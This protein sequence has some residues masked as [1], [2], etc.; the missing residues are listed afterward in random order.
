MDDD[1]LDNDATTQATQA[2]LELEYQPP[3]RELLAVGDPAHSQWGHDPEERF[4]GGVVLSVVHTP[5]EE[6]FYTV[7]YS[8]GD[9]EFFK[10][11]RRRRPGVR[12]SLG[13]G[14]GLLSVPY[15]LHAGGSGVLVTL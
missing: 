6:V 8:D 7:L 10:Q 5:G 15:T 13:L 11:A 9:V 4:F 3:K 14:L 2:L 1:S 12:G